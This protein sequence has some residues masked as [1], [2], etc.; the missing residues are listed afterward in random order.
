VRATIARHE[1]P[2]PRKLSCADEPETV[3]AYELVEVS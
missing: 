2:R 1:D 3:P